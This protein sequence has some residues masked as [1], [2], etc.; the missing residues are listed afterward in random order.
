L[1]HSL[2]AWVFV[3]YDKLI[4]VSRYADARK[5]HITDVL[6]KIEDRLLRL[7]YVTETCFDHQSWFKVDLD[8]ADF[9]VAARRLEAVKRKAQTLLNS[10]G[11]GA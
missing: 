9:K 6:D 3:D 5:V 8:T 2:T 11:Y 4:G 7:K 1:E 10:Y